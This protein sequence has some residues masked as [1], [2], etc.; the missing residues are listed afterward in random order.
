MLNYVKSKPLL[1]I[2]SSY[3]FVLDY[4]S[5]MLVS[6]RSTRAVYIYLVHIYLLFIQ[7]SVIS[8]CLQK[9]CQL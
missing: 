4:D 5:N 1:L 8:D 9:F 6:V 7:C 2:L 3:V